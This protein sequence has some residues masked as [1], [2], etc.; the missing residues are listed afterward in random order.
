MWSVVTESP[1]FASTRA[2]A[3]SVTGRG[4][5][6]SCRRSTGACARRSSSRP[7]RTWLR[8][9]VGSERQRSSPSNTLAYSCVNISVSIELSIVFCTSAA[10]GQMSLRKTSLPSWSCAERVGLE[11]EVHRPGEGVGDHER[12]AR[13]VVHLHVGVDA[14]LEVAVAREHRGHGEVVLVDRGRDLVDAADRSCRCR[15]CS[16]S[17]RC[18]SRAPRGRR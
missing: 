10:S 4:L 6:A 16:R 3:M 1:S 14:A 8:S 9:G 17:R 2:P 15:S 13:E 12:R 7:T 5:D 11:V 18:R